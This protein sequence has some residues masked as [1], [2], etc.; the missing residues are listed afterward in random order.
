MERRE[1]T[2]GKWSGISTAIAPPHALTGLLTQEDS[3]HSRSQGNSWAQHL[4]SA[5]SYF[6]KGHP[7]LHQL[8]PVAEQ[9]RL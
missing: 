7:P 4:P 6:W 1:V 3:G 9:K 2:E 8:H 5:W